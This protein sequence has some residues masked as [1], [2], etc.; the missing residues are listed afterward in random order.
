MQFVCAALFD[1]S[2]GPHGPDHWGELKADWSLCKSGAQQSPLAI[3][4]TLMITDSTLG[5]LKANYTSQLVNAT[6]S[7]DGLDLRVSV[8]NILL[9]EI[10]RPSARR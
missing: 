5:D 7:H 2:D 8:E 6:V 4:P 10:S 9:S 3:T 1:Y